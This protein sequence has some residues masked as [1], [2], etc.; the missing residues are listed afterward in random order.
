MQSMKIPADPAAVLLV[1]LGGAARER[2]AYAAG[3]ATG[4]AVM[5]DGIP[6]RR[7]TGLAV[8]VA[9]VGLDGAVVE[10][11]TALEE[12]SA[13]SIWRAE[14]A[15]ELTVRAA[16]SPGFGG[17]GPRADLVATIFV[18]RLV[19]VGSVAQVLAGPARKGDG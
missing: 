18:E 5:R 17:G 12:V 1:G 6:V 7:V 9:G 16:A 4:D 11:T 2:R 13:G 8:S 15:V 19:P 14:G 3:V 10:T